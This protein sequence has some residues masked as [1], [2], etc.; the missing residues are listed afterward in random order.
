[1]TM[2]PGNKFTFNIIGPYYFAGTI[3]L[4]N[5]VMDSDKRVFSR[6][7]NQIKN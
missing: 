2:E 6:F 1:V 7:Y 3:I 5:I 4:S